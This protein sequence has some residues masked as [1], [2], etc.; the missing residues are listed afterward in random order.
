MIVLNS[1]K[2][3]GAGFG[4]DTNKVT[5]ISSK[6][7]KI[8]NFELKSKKKVAKDILDELEKIIGIS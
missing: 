1:L 5:I 2:D 6:D 3:K 8:S 7:N 4:Y